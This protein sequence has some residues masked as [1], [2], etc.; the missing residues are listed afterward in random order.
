MQVNSQII[1]PVEKLLMARLVDI[2]T[3]LELRFMQERSDDGQLS[4]RLDPYAFLL[5]VLSMTY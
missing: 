5:A 1:R 2:M 4:Y 3:A